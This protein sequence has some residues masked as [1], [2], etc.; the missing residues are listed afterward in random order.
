MNSHWLIEIKVAF[1]SLKIVTVTQEVQSLQ[2]VRLLDK[3]GAKDAIP[4]PFLVQWKIF[5][6]KIFNIDQFFIQES[7]L[8]Q[9][10][11]T[12][13]IIWIVHIGDDILP[14]CC[15]F[16]FKLQLVSQLLITSAFVSL[17]VVDDFKRIFH[18]PSRDAVCIPVVVYVV[19]V[20]VWSSNAKHYVF[21]LVNGVVHALFPETG[22]FSE[23]FQ[24]VLTQVGLV[25]SIVHI[26]V[27]GISNCTVTMDFFKRD[28]PFVVAFFTVHRYHRVQC[29]FSKAKLF[30]IFFCFFQVL[31]TVD[32]QVAGNFRIRSTQV[33]RY[34][35]CFCIPVSAAAVFFTSEAFRTDVQTIIRAIIGLVQLEDVKPD[36]LLS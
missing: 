7:V 34:A 30:R 5:L 9:E 31:V 21:L 10:H 20:F 12:L 14:F 6:W 8:L 4:G 26:V 15:F 17:Q 19:F 32:E 11:L 22:D 35:I 13:F 28:F 25:A 3:A 16:F 23:Y 18:S 2:Y 36:R 27:D 29:T 1:L 33:E 24:T